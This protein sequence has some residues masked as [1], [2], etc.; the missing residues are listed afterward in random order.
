MLSKNNSLIFEAAF[1]VYYS[2]NKNNVMISDNE[3]A[4]T[5]RI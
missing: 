3:N 1:V 4:K 5:K 2:N